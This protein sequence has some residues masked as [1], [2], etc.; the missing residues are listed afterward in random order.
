[1]ETTVMVAIAGTAII[2]LT[3]V[4][5]SFAEKRSWWGKTG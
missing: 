4:V 1:M 2:I 5:A 3:L